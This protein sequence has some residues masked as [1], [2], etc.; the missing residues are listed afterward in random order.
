MV[1][2]FSPGKKSLKL[3]SPIKTAG[4]TPVLPAVQSPASAAYYN[5]PQTP[6]GGI[7]P[8]YNP[9]L[10]KQG[11]GLYGTDPLSSD[12]ESP[13][14]NTG[15]VKRGEQRLGANI[16]ASNLKMMA[17]VEEANLKMASTQEK[18]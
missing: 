7:N 8:N 14:S 5:M 11:L 1:G 12:S 10:P 15:S 13:Y 4:F 17:K 18:K 2:E 16:Y 3:P 6:E 9:N